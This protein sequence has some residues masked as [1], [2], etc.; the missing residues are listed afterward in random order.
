[1]IQ[2]T[3]I[4][5]S[6]IAIGSNNISNGPGAL[7]MGISNISSG[8]GAVAIGEQSTANGR[9]AIALG[10]AVHALVGPNESSNNWYAQGGVAIGEG[11]SANGRGAVALGLGDMVS[12]T[13]GGTAIGINNRVFADNAIAIGT[14]LYVDK[15][16][17]G[18]MAFGS[19]NASSTV[20]TAPNSFLILGQNVGIGTTNPTP[21][22]LLDVN[23]NLRVQGNLQVVGTK[24][25]IMDYPA[26]QP[27]KLVHLF[28]RW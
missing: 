27:N 18:T 4:Y 10:T 12:V 21:G 16:T 1:M 26:I 24:N 5:A 9:G 13:Y 6:G 17:I 25:F 14:S 19:G 15:A 20:I 11:S 7:T 23:G 8:L 28:R 3:G 2:I 22:V